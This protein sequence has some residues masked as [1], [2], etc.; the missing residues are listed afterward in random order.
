MWLNLI[1]RN[2]APIHFLKLF[3]KERTFITSSKHGRGLGTHR[4]QC[5]GHQTAALR[6]QGRN[7]PGSAAASLRRNPEQTY[8]VPATAAVDLAPQRH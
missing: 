7:L 2:F 3:C 5:T 8:G 1:Q 6:F 4:A